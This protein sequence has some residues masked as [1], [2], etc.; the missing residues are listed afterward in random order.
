MLAG[1]GLELITPVVA[2]LKCITVSS[3]MSHE[4]R[5]YPSERL[6]QIS[7]RLEMCQYDTDAPDPHPHTGF[8][9][10]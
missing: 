9:K 4:G 10:K 1:S 3:K 8:C 7:M 2:S 6:N 5:D